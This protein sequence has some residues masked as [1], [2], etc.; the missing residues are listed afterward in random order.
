MFF[1]Y[2][3]LFHLCCYHFKTSHTQKLLIIDITLFVDIWG[4]PLLYSIVIEVW[5]TALWPLHFIE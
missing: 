2:L 3:Y 5:F 1:F 4:N